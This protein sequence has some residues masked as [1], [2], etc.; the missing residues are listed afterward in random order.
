MNEYDLI[1]L[2]KLTTAEHG[3]FTFFN[4]TLAVD[5]SLEL[6]EE[7]TEYF[8]DAS[9]III[10]IETNEIFCYD[11]HGNCY[12][13][14]FYNHFLDQILQNKVNDLLDDNYER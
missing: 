14:G 3:W 2:L 6:A 7:L 1:R 12:D 4:Q 9:K 5:I 11:D 10:D 8:E 13:Q